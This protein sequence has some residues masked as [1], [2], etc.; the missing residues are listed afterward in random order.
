MIRFCVPMRLFSGFN[1]ELSSDLKNHL[2]FTWIF[3]DIPEK[4]GIILAI[5]LVRDILTGI[6]FRVKIARKTS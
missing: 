3:T 2:I 4:A 1:V 6:D 5:Q